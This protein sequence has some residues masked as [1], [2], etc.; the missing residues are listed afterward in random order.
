M[1]EILIVAVA[2]L[3]IIVGGLVMVLSDLKN[4]LKDLKKKVSQV[5]EERYLLFLDLHKHKGDF[6]EVCRLLNIRKSPQVQSKWVK[7]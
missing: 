5:D 4:N 6:A 7:D 2:I 1:N 3:G